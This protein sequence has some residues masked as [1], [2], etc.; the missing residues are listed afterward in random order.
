MPIAVRPAV[1]GDAPDLV[2][3]NVRAWRE[4]YAGI[5]PADAL[6]AIDVPTRL[7]RFERRLA[8]PGDADVLV[9]HDGYRRLGYAHLGPYRLEQGGDAVEPEV[10]ELRAMYV[11]PLAWRRGVGSALMSAVLIRVAE[12]GWSQVRLWVLEANQRA[13]RFYERTGFAPDGTRAAYRVNRPLGLV[14]ELPEIRYRRG[15]TG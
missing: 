14:T 4:A 5:I 7:D 3:I 12:R 1:A 6:D 10:A 9:A 8:E 15:V 2:D 11:D 13:R